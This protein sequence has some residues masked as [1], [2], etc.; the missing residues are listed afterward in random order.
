MWNSRMESIGPTMHPACPSRMI[1]HYLWVGQ[2]S[3]N[4]IVTLTINLSCLLQMSEP[5]WSMDTV[6][7]QDGMIMW[8]KVGWEWGEDCHVVLLHMVM[9]YVHSSESEMTNCQ[10]SWQLLLYSE[11]WG[12]VWSCWVMAVSRVLVSNSKSVLNAW[13]NVGEVPICSVLEWFFP[14]IGGKWG[15]YLLQKCWEFDLINWTTWVQC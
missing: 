14:P 15:G 9:N 4:R 10:S 11:G 6:N 8:R 12:H 5:V 7:C 1:L 3:K 2:H 13:C